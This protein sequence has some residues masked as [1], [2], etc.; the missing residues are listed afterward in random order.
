MIVKEYVERAAKGHP[1]T[2]AGHAAEKQMAFYLRRAFAD[3]DGLFVLNDLR[4][5]DPERQIE[6]ASAEDASQID[7]LVLHR[8]GMFIIESKSCTGEICINDDGSGGDEWTFNK[9]GRNSPLKQAGR[10]ADYLR[11]FLTQHHESL[12][13]KHAVGTRTLAKML[14]GTDQRT[15]TRMPMQ[16]IVAIA[17]SATIKRRKWKEPSTP[18]QHYVCKAD[19]VCDKVIAE[20]GRHQKAASPLGKPDGDYGLWSMKLEEVAAIAYFLNEHHTPRKN[21]V[22]QS[23]SS[24]TATK[25]SVPSKPGAVVVQAACK[26]CNGHNLEGRWGRYGYH[27]S[28]KDCDSN[29]SMPRVCGACGIDGKASKQVKIRKEGSKFYRSCIPCGIEELIWKNQ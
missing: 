12:L 3:H 23:P 13:G 14:K 10:Q 15:V 22:K 6:G 25:A 1:R 21:K 19:L 29:T 2:R 28:C 26:E 27:W 5:V 9:Q 16:A 18:F 24:A 11:K 17:E 20:Y 8:W 4:I 7:H